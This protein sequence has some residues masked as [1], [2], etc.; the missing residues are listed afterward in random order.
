MKNNIIIPLPKLEDTVAVIKRRENYAVTRDL[1]ALEFNEA[2]AKRVLTKA[3][4]LTKCEKCG[5]EFSTGTASEDSSTCP[6]C[7]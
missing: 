2:I 3:S 4:D 6:E 7:R 5:K 1:Q